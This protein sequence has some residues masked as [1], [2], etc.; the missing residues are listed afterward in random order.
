MSTH[1]ARL[2]SVGTLETV[3]YQAVKTCVERVKQ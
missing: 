2:A 3:R 1:S